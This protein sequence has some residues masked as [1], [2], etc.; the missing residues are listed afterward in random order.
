M[1]ALETINVEVSLARHSGEIQTPRLSI[2]GN[3][4][5]PDYMPTTW[6]QESVACYAREAKAIV[7]AL[8]RTLPGGTID[9]IHIEMCKIKASAL[10]I[11]DENWRKRVEGMTPGG[12]S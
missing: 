8:V 11:L 10:I 1:T 4:E 9:Q 5:I 6:L 3:A 12:A 7:D 2:V